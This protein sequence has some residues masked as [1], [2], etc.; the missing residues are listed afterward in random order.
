MVKY[1]NQPLHSLSQ[2]YSI[3]VNIFPILTFFS[4]FSPILE[5]LPI[6]ICRK[7][8]LIKYFKKEKWR[9]IIF[10]KNNK[11]ISCLILVFIVVAS[12]G[13]ILLLM[14]L[15]YLFHAMSIDFK[16]TTCFGICLDFKHLRVKA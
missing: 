4:K 5:N 1:I 7:A 9:I 13:G 15:K 10:F 16:S 3:I 8:K 2:L 14:S 12:L 6:V 11:I